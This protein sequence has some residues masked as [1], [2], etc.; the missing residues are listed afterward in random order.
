MAAT[1]S[2]RF[3]PSMARR[4]AELEALDRRLGAPHLLEEPARDD[5]GARHRRGPLDGGRG[6]PQRGLGLV[7]EEERERAVNRRVG[8]LG[9]GQVRRGNTHWG[10]L[11]YHCS[12][13]SFFP[14]SERS[15]NSLIAL[16]VAAT[17]GKTRG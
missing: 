15:M 4:T 12:L 11:S 9:A 8:R 16:A 5:Q 3:A 17:R 13:G 10:P 7:G 2:G 6:P 14:A 1:A